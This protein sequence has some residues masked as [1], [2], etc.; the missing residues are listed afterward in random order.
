MTTHVLNLVSF[1]DRKA[2]LQRDLE[3]AEQAYSEAALADA[4]G[5]GTDADMISAKATV[6]LAKDRIAALDAAWQQA[7]KHHL[8]EKKADQ[9]ETYRQ[10]V[11]DLDAALAKRRK[12]ADTAIKAAEALAD[13]QLAFEACEA[14][15]QKLA[16]DCE[17]ATRVKRLVEGVRMAVPSAILSG[18]GESVADRRRRPEPRSNIPTPSEEA[19]R[20]LD[21]SDE[22]L[23]GQAALHAP[24][25]LMEN[26]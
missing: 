24:E 4:V 17:A 23:R 26:A 19:L 12:A 15:I 10:F 21:R 8:A 22:R 14:D 18:L 9:A 1:T 16:A 3:T 7:Q 6:E 13:A 20:K 25:T 2:Q 5:T 11:S